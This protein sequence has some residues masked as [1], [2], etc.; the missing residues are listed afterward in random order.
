MAVLY[1]HGVSSYVQS[2]ESFAQYQ[3]TSD[4]EGSA[5]TVGGGMGSIIELPNSPPTT[6]HLLSLSNEI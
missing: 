2:C 3:V 5:L 1:V 4:S 6:L